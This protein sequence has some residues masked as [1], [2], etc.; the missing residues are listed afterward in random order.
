MGKVSVDD[1]ARTELTDVRYEQAHWRFTVATFLGGVMALSVMFSLLFLQGFDS[2]CDRL[3][4]CALVPILQ[5][6]NVMFAA[7]AGPAKAAARPRAAK[8][9]KERWRMFLFLLPCV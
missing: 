4:S 3:R 9:A 5:A 6:G 2:T 1:S 7:V 8:A